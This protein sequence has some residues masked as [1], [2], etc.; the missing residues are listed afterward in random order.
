MRKPENGVQTVHLCAEGGRPGVRR[1][2]TPAHES[3]KSRR[4]RRLGS[5][6][7]LTY[8]H[9]APPTLQGGP[10]ARVAPSQTSQIRPRPLG[11]ESPL[12]ARE[13]GKGAHGWL[14]DILVDEVEFC[15]VGP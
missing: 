1:Y 4:S 13:T 3:P 10:S 9:V 12:L 2:R 5:A 15:D 14:A 6:T 8:A 11:P 7:A